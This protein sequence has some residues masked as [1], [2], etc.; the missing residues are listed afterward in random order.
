V[1]NFLIIEIV[2]SG[3]KDFYKLAKLEDIFNIMGYWNTI[4]GEIVDCQEVGAF[5]LRTRITIGDYLIDFYKLRDIIIAFKFQNIH[6]RKISWKL[7]NCQGISLISN[8]FYHSK[9]E[10]QKSYI[11]IYIYTKHTQALTCH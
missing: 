4:V 1:K 6:R 2:I 3:L 9:K 11:Y 10:V 7:G 5:G 8:R